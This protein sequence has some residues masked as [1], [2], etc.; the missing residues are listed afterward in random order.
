MTT[1]E[2]RRNLV[3]ETLEEYKMN[4]ISISDAANAMDVHYGVRCPKC[5]STEIG[6]FACTT[7]RGCKECSTEVPR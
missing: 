6:F 4:H 1:P 7:A 2:E 5:G 3:M